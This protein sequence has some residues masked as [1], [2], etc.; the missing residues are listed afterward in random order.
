MIENT[1]LELRA[2]NYS[3]TTEISAVESC[4]G[5]LELTQAVER[6]IRGFGFDYFRYTGNFLL[7]RQKSISKTFSNFPNK[8]IERY[9]TC[10]YEKVDPIFHYA[11]T[12][13]APAIWSKFAR[14]EVLSAEQI[15]YFTDAR[16]HEIGG[17]VSYPVQMRNGDSAILSLAN[18]IDRRDTEQ[19][20]ARSLAEGCLTA[21]L[22]HDSMRRIVDTERNVLQAPLTNRELECLRWIAIGKSNWEIAAIFGISEHGAV[23][24]VRKLLWKLGATNRHQAVERATACG[25][26]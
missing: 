21:T 24:Y 18:H 3:F 17:G 2:V 6:I 22:V 4:I 11:I 5:E 19:I 10:E 20:I 16:A 8:W 23:Y 7:D 14:E 25:L 1:S 26:L 15:R 13:V 12:H 9:T